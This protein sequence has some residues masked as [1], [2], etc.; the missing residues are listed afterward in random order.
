MSKIGRILSD[1]KGDSI[2]GFV[3]ISPFLV[4]FILYLVLGGAYFMRINDMANIC[5]KKLD[6]ALVEGQFTSTLRS[7]LESE[8]ATYGFSGT[9]LEIVITPSRAGDGSDGTYV[10]RG[11]EIELQVLYKKPHWFYYINRFLSPSLEESKFYI[12]TKIS[13]MSEKW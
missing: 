8:L 1:K 3:I 9:E 12:G 11:Q 5:N 10:N 7:E 2:L 6:R 13:G 4:Y